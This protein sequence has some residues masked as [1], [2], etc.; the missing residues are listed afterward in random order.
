[1]INFLDKAKKCVDTKFGSSHRKNNLRSV[2][3]SLAPFLSI[4]IWRSEQ[5]L[6][7]FAV[8]QIAPQKIIIDMLSI[9]CFCK[10]NTEIETQSVF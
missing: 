4:A 10:I 7:I 6:T 8:G 3:S 5:I 9:L 1:V 2:F